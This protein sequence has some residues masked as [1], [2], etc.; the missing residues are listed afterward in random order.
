MSKDDKVMDA[1]EQG[2]GA[3]TS[4]LHGFH[5]GVEKLTL[6]QCRD[7]LALHHSTV[8]VSLCTNP[9]PAFQAR[10]CRQYVFRLCLGGSFCLLRLSPFRKNS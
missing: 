9:H 1:I 8:K 4:A 10:I 6:V 7:L 5:A 3:A 2:L